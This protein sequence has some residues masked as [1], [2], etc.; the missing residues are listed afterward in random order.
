MTIGGDGPAADVELLR[1]HGDGE[2]W[3]DLTDLDA[4]EMAFEKIH[5]SGE[6]GFVPSQRFIDL[7]ALMRSQFD[8]NGVA[9]PKLHRPLSV[10]RELEGLDVL[11]SSLSGRLAHPFHRRDGAVFR[12][13]ASFALAGHAGRQLER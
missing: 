12:H 4:V 2:F 7:E 6:R 13:R 11:T 1:Q 10:R 5:P 8:Q 3:P 9:N